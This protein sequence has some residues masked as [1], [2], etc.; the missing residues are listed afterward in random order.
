MH[1]Q[2]LS[3]EEYRNGPNVQTRTKN[4]DPTRGQLWL[5]GLWNMWNI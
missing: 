1:M 4:L 3:Y 5:A 2:T